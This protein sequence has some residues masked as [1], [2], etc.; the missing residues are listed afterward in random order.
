MLAAS[1]CHEKVVDCVLDNGADPSV[2]DCYGMDALHHAAKGGNTNIITTLIR[3]GVDLN[4][5]DNRGATSLIIAASCG[6][7]AA[8]DILADAGAD[9]SIAD[10]EGCSALHRASSSKNLNI[11]EKLVSTYPSNI[12]DENKSG[13]TPLR[14]AASRNNKEAS[15]YLKA[16]GGTMKDSL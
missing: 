14:I 13:E 6:N 12:N 16:R 9:M 10:N 11:L 8:V 2:V 1:Q 4:T 15:D 3:R 5:R 7:A